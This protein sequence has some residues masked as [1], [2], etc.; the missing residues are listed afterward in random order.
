MAQD[1]CRSDGGNPKG[2]DKELVT[3]PQNGWEQGGQ[4]LINLLTVE[5]DT[6]D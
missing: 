3:G 5:T 1:N 6:H 4:H 2:P